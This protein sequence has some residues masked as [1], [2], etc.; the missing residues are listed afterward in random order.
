[1]K[2]SKFITYSRNDWRNSLCSYH[3]FRCMFARLGAAMMNTTTGGESTESQLHTIALELL[4]AYFAVRSFKETIINKNTR[5]ML[6]NN[7]AVCIINKTGTTL[8]SNCNNVAVQIGDF[9]QA[10]NIL[11][12]AFRIHGAQSVNHDTELPVFTNPDAQWRLNPNV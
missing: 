4:A 9:C 12:T 6:D 1:M 7:V 10:H 11:L 5:L 3:L 8:S 2:A